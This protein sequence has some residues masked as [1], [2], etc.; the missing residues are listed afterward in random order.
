MCELSVY[1]K[2]ESEILGNAYRRSLECAIAQHCQSVAFPAISTGVYRFPKDRAA[3]ISS[4]AI[5]E[6]LLGH[7]AINKV[8]LVSFA[9]EDAETF[10]NHH[11]FSNQ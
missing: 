3:Q 4:K 10:L 5:Q 7:K 2:G 8:M 11:V 9:E 1:M 6:F